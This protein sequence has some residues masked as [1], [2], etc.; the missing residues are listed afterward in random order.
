M[1]HNLLT[2]MIYRYF[3]RRDEELEIQI[4]RIKDTLKRQKHDQGYL[5]SDLGELLRQQRFLRE[6]EKDII[7]IL[8]IYYK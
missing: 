6:L 2:I 5:Y 7:E 8:K 1:Q 4:G 3:L